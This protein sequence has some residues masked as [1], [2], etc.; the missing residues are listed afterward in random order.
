MNNITFAY[1]TTPLEMAES[2]A[3]NRDCLGCIC[4]YE[5]AKVVDRP[6]SAQAMSPD[7][8]PFIR[9]FHRRGDLLRRAEVVADVAVLRSF[10]SQVFADARHAQATYRAEQAMI[11]N[12]VPFQIIYDRH[13]A[14][15]GRYRTLF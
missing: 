1:T 5:S 12:G 8:A 6:Y 7:L 13:L 9:F 14:D 2:M 3:F 15:L 11:E 10:P 4:W